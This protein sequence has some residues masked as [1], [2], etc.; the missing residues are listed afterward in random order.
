MLDERLILGY[1]F[2]GKFIGHSTFNLV[3]DTGKGEQ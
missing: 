3:R 1:N 2:F